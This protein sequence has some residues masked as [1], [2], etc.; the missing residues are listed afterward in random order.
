MTNV[1]TFTP[2]DEE[3][4]RRV[5]ESLDETLFVEAG[6]GTGKTTSLVDRVTRLV[7][8]GTATMDRIAAITF[9]EAAAA[10]LRDRVRER[11]ELSAGD[12]EVS[13]EERARCNQGVAG[14][15]QASVQTLHGFATS[16]LQE[17]PLEAGLPPSFE[18][19][20]TISGDLA[21][22]EAW[23]TWIDGALEDAEL[24]PTLASAFSLGLRIPHLRDVALKFHENYDLLE[25]AA[26]DDPPGPTLS[27]VLPLVE[28]SEELERLGQFSRL[29]ENDALFAHTQRLL[30]EVSQLA[31]LDP[32][33]PVVYRLLDRL[34]VSTNAGNQGNW[35]VDPASG[36]N[37][38]RVMKELLRNLR[39]ETQDRLT[40]ARKA[41]LMPLLRELRRF[42]LEYA[43][44]R[45]R[46]GRAGFQDL[47]VWAR[48]LVRDN[49]EIR[50][51]FR[52][53]F[54]HL[55]IDEAQDTDPIQAEIA[56]FLAEDVSP[57]TPTEERPRSWLEVAPEKGKLFVVGDPKQSIYRFRRADVA[58]MQRL[59]ERMNGDTLYLVQN[60][61][62]QRPVL[63]WVNHVFERWMQEGDQQAE[64]VPVLPRW[65]AATQ[66]EA[67]PRVWR[68][69]GMREGRAD[70]VRQEEA[71]YIARLL[72]A[73]TSQPWQVL[74]QETTAEA[75]EEVYRPAQLSDICI[76]MPRRTGIRTLELAL[77]DAGVAYRLE[78]ASL[79]F[80]T[81]E[82]RDLVNCLRAIDDPSDQV[83]L[84]AALRSPAFVCSDVDLLQFSQKGGRFDYL[85]APP[86]GESQKNGAG[87][88]ELTLESL[89]EYHQDRYW[90]S[91]AGLI[92]RFIRDRLLMEAALGHPRTREQWRRY[93][94][95]V[96]QARAFAEAGG[97]SLRD[98]L[99]WVDRQT[100]EGAR[101]TET[102]VPETDEEAVRIMTVH[103]AKGLEFPIVVL[104]GLGSGGARR[105]ECVLFDRSQGL[106]EV[107][108]GASGSG[109]LDNR[110]RTEGYEQLEELENRMSGDEAVRLLYVAATRA[111]DHLAVSLYRTQRG[112]NRPGD[113]IEA[114]LAEDDHLWEA[115]P[116]DLP[117][118][119]PPVQDPGDHSQEPD[120][121][122]QARED[123]LERRER[124]YLEQVRPRSVAATGLAKA[125]PGDG[126]GIPEPVNRAA[127][128]ALEIIDQH[129]KAGFGET[130][131]EAASAAGIPDLAGEVAELLQDLVGRKEEPEDGDA[132]K[133]GRGA[134]SLG[135]AV[136]AALQTVDLRTGQG[137][138]EASR[139][140]ATAEGIPE[141]WEE[142]AGLVRAALD[143]EVVR[144]AV[145][146]QGFWREA[147]VAIPVGGGVL[148]GFIDLL[149]QDED[150]LVVV[151]YKTDAV[152]AEE[153]EQTAQRYRLQAG[154]YALAVE[155]AT[156][157]RVS[158]VILLF[159]RPG[160]AVS[161]KDVT[162]LAQEAEA[163]ALAVLPPGP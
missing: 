29:G 6:A 66:D 57:G 40:G 9:T 2:Q 152:S 69:G 115:T 12:L 55:L 51:H 121:S 149:Y 156:G 151:D 47:L 68:I 96:E 38:A 131:R 24:R 88:V 62:S 106:V 46:Q 146:S 97:D 154:S 89:R 162:G 135:R 60:F 98:F 36:Y 64:Y 84:V 136:H 145:A 100:T 35:D 11:L 95:L 138:N 125:V 26:F 99:E 25:G 114:F 142:V 7:S 112:Q 116:E 13:A 44:E 122:P 86:D 14:L 22:E 3:V 92:D 49:L 141:R 150:G 42:V 85:A 148:E 143:S 48:D 80:A 163:A 160:E 53:K 155:R 139:A 28:A 65:E 73:M 124:V 111:R 144:T 113:K 93:R 17:K 39:D 61:R 126:S 19:M 27:P 37:A 127:R 104:I 56:M 128:A 158:Q 50:D 129:P 43:R 120:Y 90:G 1:V 41:A 31:T 83:A 77:D 105:Q 140:Q 130:C 91:V 71:E 153:V 82:V 54:S 74:D 147:P 8:T 45:K 33:S 133:R 5:R 81:Q 4:R 79:I 15:D 137:L 101:V 30:G 16:L 108:A 18:V 118:P 58:Q 94:F 34:R 157:E 119:P 70:D 103:G 59:Q 159:L 63:E 87:P 10:E 110:F 78:G 67:G 23:E 52:G 20:D 21:F 32:Q 107:A 134:T 132:W 76:L 109:N 161:F 72:H 117:P 123:W 102:P 75:G